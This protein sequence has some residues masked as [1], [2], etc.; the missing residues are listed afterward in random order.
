MAAN[1]STGDQPGNFPISPPESVENY[2]KWWVLIAIGVGTY[3]SALDGSVV[4]TILPVIKQHFGINVAAIEWVVIIYLLVLSGLLL[5]FGRLG[6]IRGH[7][8]IY[9]TGFLVFLF[10]SLLCGISPSVGY[11]VLFRAIQAFGGAMIQ[12]NSPAIITKSFPGT[13]RGQA[14][15]LVA[16]MTYLGLTTG[17]SF[18]GWLAQTF[19][20]RAVFYIN[21][22]IGLIALIL[23]WRFIA[24]DRPKTQDERFDIP[25]AIT[26][27]GGLILLLLGLNQ[28]YKLGWNSPQIILLLSSALVLLFIFLKIE[29][30][31]D[32]PML[33]LGLFK[34]SI[35]SS[36]VA[37]AILNYICVYG[38]LFL[39]PFYLI[40]GRNFSPAQAGMLLTAQP[41]I[42]ALV[43]PISGSLSDRIGTRAPTTIGMLV[44][45]LGLFLLSRLGIDSP[46]SQIIVSL[47]VAGLG[48]GVFISP[49]NS[50][51]MGAAPRKRQ[52]IAA[53]I[54]ATARNL[55]MVLGVG[56]AGAIFTTYYGADHIARPES[57]F[58]AIQ[59]SFMITSL[60]AI[61][62]AVVTMI[63]FAKDVQLL[64]SQ[65]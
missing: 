42:M 33:D 36:S 39:L 43:A 62:G 3:M 8:V 47:G 51:L 52:G 11:L 64:P 28:G 60:F 19:S 41:I 57:L 38:I 58:A 14:L 6:D 25:G 2:S 55:G 53:G 40:D 13:Q 18:G 50:A 63:Q 9:L 4:N 22:P 1:K 10:G 45:A 17:P 61:L 30:G 27:T 20:W 29:Q 46:K 54:L 65:D 31:A 49:N 48:I 7:K 5:S 59:S 23:S 44:L 32:N 15:G 26:F 21:I 12:A 16:T 24:A 37:S 34:N 56:F 35:F